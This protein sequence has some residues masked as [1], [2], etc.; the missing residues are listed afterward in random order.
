MRKRSW[1]TTIAAIIA[2]ALEVLIHQIGIED[3][4]LKSIPTVAVAA[5]LI[6]AKDEDQD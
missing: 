4:G 5:G 3:K 1:K 2:L 6:V